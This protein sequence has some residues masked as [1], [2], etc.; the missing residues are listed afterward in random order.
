MKE[1]I[2]P[3]IFTVA[4]TVFHSLSDLEI[5]V[6]AIK[7]YIYIFIYRSFGRIYKGR[8]AQW[9]ERG[10]SKQQTGVRFRPRVVR[11]NWAAPLWKEFPPVSLCL[12][13]VYCIIWRDIT[14][15][16]KISH[17]FQTQGIYIYM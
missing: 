14:E 15:F 9:N 6:R 4:K 2:T 5:V 7:L 1:I 12:V 3:E 10:F 8:L 17:A 16:L 11:Y 13:I